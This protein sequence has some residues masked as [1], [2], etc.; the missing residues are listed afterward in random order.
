VIAEAPTGGADVHAA[1]RSAALLV[2]V[3]PRRLRGRTEVPLWAYGV[4]GVLS[5]LLV[6]LLVSALELVDGDSLPGPFAVLGRVGDLLTSASFLAEVAQTVW[7]WGL[8]MVIGFVIAVPIG[9]LMGYYVQLYR[10]ASTVVNAARSVPAVALLPVAILSFGLGTQL[11]VSLA[12]Y[13]VFWL[14]LVN[15]MYGVREAEPTMLAAGRSM[16]WRQRQL[17]T[18]VVLPS[19]A[20]SIATGIRVA[21]STALVVILSTELLGASNGIGT[22]ITRYGQS[23]QSDFV[24]AGILII[25]A[26]GTAIYYALNYVERRLLPWSHSSRSEAR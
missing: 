1:E 20:P 11:K 10:P 13:A 26:I 21:S 14:I 5:F 7:A 18:R 4:A 22:V 8:T 9:L 16:G 23:Q 12:L 3:Q 19:A 2:S 24:Y 15:A 6:W 17:L 25:G